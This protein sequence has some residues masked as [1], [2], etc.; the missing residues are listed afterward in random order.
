MTRKNSLQHVVRTG[1]VLQQQPTSTLRK[2]G[3]LP[4]AKMGCKGPFHP[5]THHITQARVGCGEATTP[6]TTSAMW[7]WDRGWL[8]TPCTTTCSCRVDFSYR[9]LFLPLF[10]VLENMLL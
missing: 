3:V 5:T 1:G 7:G 2:R 4:R 10:I 9:H 6:T 8:I